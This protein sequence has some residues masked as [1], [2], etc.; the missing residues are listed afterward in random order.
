VII[1]CADA[2]RRTAAASSLIARAAVALPDRFA[3]GL[4]SSGPNN[5]RRR[6][7]VREMLQTVTRL[8]SHFAPLPCG[9]RQRLNHVLG[10]NEGAM[11]R[12]ELCRRA[13]MNSG[14]RA[15]LGLRFL[16][17]RPGVNDDGC[18]KKSHLRPR[19][20][21]GSGR[22]KSGQIDVARRAAELKKRRRDYFPAKYLLPCR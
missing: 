15:S 14:K 1:D 4:R 19:H 8:P 20:R 17:S 6:Q 9:S 13:S 5:P 3:L 10:I 12:A 21:I 16:A 18:S 22:T 11:S 7:S 2:E